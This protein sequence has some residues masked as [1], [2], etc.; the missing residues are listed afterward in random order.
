ME[1]RVKVT[2]V[3]RVRVINSNRAARQSTRHPRSGANHN[4]VEIAGVVHPYL[5][6]YLVADLPGSAGCWSG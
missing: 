2:R 6:K 4:E 1:N 3:L 5:M